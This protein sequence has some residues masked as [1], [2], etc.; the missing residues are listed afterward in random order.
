M[1]NKDSTINAATSYQHAADRLM[2]EAARQRAIEDRARAATAGADFLTPDW[3]DLSP[4]SVMSL[5]EA[6]ALACGISKHCAWAIEH[7]VGEGVALDAVES[8]R[9]LMKYLTVRHGITPRT[10]VPLDSVAEWVRDAGM[11][12]PLGFPARRS[13]LEDA[14][15]RMPEAPTT[16]AAAWALRK[17][18]RFQ[19]YTKPLYDFLKGEHIA[20]RPRPKA[21]DVLDAWSKSPPLDVAK[22]TTDSFDYSNANGRTDTANV[23]AI[24]KAIARMTR[25][26]TDSANKRPTRPTS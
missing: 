10:E 14:Q 9:K 1:N 22:V 17:P 5:R 20:G 18:E 12:L 13:C 6:V 16:V 4:I 25:K 15:S 24:R 21:H 23:S 11:R 26:A 2:P 7:G 19:G 8:A 3:S